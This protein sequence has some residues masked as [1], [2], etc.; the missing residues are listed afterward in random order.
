[1]TMRGATEFAVASLL[2]A[3][4]TW[5][6]GWWM[7][8]VIAAIWGAVRAEDRWLPL[9]AAFAGTTSWLLLLFLPSSPGAVGRLATVA[10]RAMGVG[11]GPLVLLT[12]VFPALLAVA[13]AALARAVA[14]R[15]AA[16]ATSSA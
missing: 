16:S 2:M 10:G 5:F 8:P 1:M 15:R 12:L 11:P 9:L 3:T 14:P 4:G 7:V 13:A 6:V